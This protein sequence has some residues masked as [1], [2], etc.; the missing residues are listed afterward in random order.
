MRGDY[1]AIDWGTTNRRIYVIGGDG[2]LRHTRRD[3]CGAL[4]M[5]RSDYPAEIGAI[6]ADYG[7]LPVIASGMVGSSRGWV[8]VPYC[9]APASIADLAAAAHACGDRVFIV[10]GISVHDQRGCDVM[11]GEEV[12][13][14]GALIS[15]A[16]SSGALFCQPG[17]HSKWIATDDIRICALST[18]MTGELFALLKSGSVLAEMLQGAVTNGPAF[19][20]GVARG[21]GATDLPSALFQ[22]RAAALLGARAAQ[23]TASYV[24][25]L[26]IGSDVGARDLAGRVVT[27]LADGDLAILYRA[28]IEIAGG[29]VEVIDSNA[30]FT[31][32]IQAIYEAM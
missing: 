2:S 7:D 30:A 19:A 15:G 22:A 32:G 28:A 29:T 1:I 26:L 31:A 21:M 5:A 18:A 8:D 12:Q 13:V 25:G 9:P 3:H 20:E 23:D 14:F 6:R 27:L 16:V 4:R 17:T 10:P 11:R 24:S